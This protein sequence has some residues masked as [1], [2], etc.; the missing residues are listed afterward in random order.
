MGWG[1]GNDFKEATQAATPDLARAYALQGQLDSAEQARVDAVRANNAAGIIGLGE[2]GFSE[3]KDWKAKQKPSVNKPLSVFDTMQ[4]EAMAARAANT[5]V[6]LDTPFINKNT[7]SMGF[8]KDYNLSGAA[9]PDINMSARG[10]G[11]LPPNVLSYGFQPDTSFLDGPASQNMQAPS[12]EALK[13]V[14]TPRPFMRPKTANA[15]KNAYAN[16]NDNTTTAGKAHDNVTG[17]FNDKADSYQDWAGGVNE[18]ANSLRNDVIGS[19]NGDEAP[20]SGFMGGRTVTNPAEID[21]IGSAIDIESMNPA[22]KDQLMNSIGMPDTGADIGA[23]VA[24]DVAEDA[25]LDAASTAL[26]GLGGTAGVS[27]LEGILSGD[28]V[29]TIAKDVA[30]DAGQATLLSSLGL[31]GPLG[32]GVGALIS[33]LRA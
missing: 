30:L 9:R 7:N 2:K 8:T 33:A 4:N 24:A 16:Y 27:A 19:F 6:T 14:A 31:T 23:D 22:V 32:W 21:K 5:G 3:Y 17:W 20:T 10:G 13:K 11:N 26:D 15:I 25:T 28:D 12:E 29:G 18:R 1:M